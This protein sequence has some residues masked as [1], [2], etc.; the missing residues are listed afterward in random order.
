MLELR[1]AHQRDPNHR[2]R[3]GRSKKVVT[4]SIGPAAEDAPICTGCRS[5]KA[6]PQ[7]TYLLSFPCEAFCRVFVSM[8]RTDEFFF[9]SGFY[10]LSPIFV[11]F[12]DLYDYPAISVS[13]VRP[14]SDSSPPARVNRM[15]SAAQYYWPPSPHLTVM[16]RTRMRPTAPK[17][18]VL[19]LR[20]YGLRPLSAAFAY[21]ICCIFLPVRDSEGARLG[22]A[23]TEVSASCHSQNTL[24]DF[25]G[26]AKNYRQY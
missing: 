22:I 7:V 6:A 15:T 1:P 10:F 21:L 20:V 19:G 16:K 8:L 12:G 23:E 18:R 3:I 9:I 5:E 25:Q 2:D 24:H 14:S 4:T 11:V 13:K 17:T 26:K